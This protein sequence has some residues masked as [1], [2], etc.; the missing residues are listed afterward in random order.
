MY[1]QHFPLK[2]FPQTGT[3]THLCPPQT[4]KTLCLSNK[5]SAKPPKDFSKHQPLINFIF[6]LLLLLLPTQESTSSCRPFRMV[7][8]LRVVRRTCRRRRPRRRHQRRCHRR[9]RSPPAVR[10][11]RCRS[12]SRSHRGRQEFGG[13]ESW[14]VN[15]GRRIIYKIYI[16]F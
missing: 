7:P 5:N 13:W 3:K 16:Y 14:W 8:A 4:K 6:L 15:V 1:Q 11:R 2:Q 9:S 12:R 10:G